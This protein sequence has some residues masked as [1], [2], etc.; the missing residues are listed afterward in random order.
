MVISNPVTLLVVDD[1][2]DNQMLFAMKLRSHGITVLQALSGAEALAILEEIRPDA[3]FLDRMMPHMDGLEVAR[4]IRANPA[5]A[6][7]PI[8]MITALDSSLHVVQGYKAGVN[9]YVSKPIDWEILM[10]RLEVQLNLVALRRNAE[11]TAQKL[12]RELQAARAIQQGLLPEVSEL[13][14]L[15]D[16]YGVELRA[17]WEPTRYLGGDFWDLLPLADGSLGILLIDFAGTGVATSFHT[18]RAKTFAHAQCLNLYS[19]ALTLSRL[20]SHFLSVFSPFELATASYAIYHPDNRTL[21]FASAGGPSPLVCRANGKG[22]QAVRATGY[23]LGAFPEAS[24]K[25]TTIELEPGD[26]VLFFTDGLRKLES[27]DGVQVKERQLGEF[28][29]HCSGGTLDF[30]NKELQTLIEPYRFV[31]AYPDDLTVVFFRVL[32]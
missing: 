12:E 6:D 32:E 15:P 31:S 18:I 23:P 13:N 1:D 27:P 21:E 16:S 22:V 4:T 26:L 19:P 24:W 9:D 8:I 5:W 3:V 20:N 11:L 29:M 2:P 28:L 17:T 25:E 14:R 30:M 7:L 10:V